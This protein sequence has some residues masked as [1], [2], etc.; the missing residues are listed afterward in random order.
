MIASKNIFQVY[1]VSALNSLMVKN[2]LNNKCLDKI[3]EF[4]DTI[5]IIIRE[6]HIILK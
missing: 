5:Y 2:I 4:Y 3:H 1:V 6:S